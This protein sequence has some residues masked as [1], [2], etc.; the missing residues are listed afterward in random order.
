M[1]ET[2]A[3]AQHQ[4]QCATTDDDV[5]HMCLPCF[6]Q[7]LQLQHHKLQGLDDNASRDLFRACHNLTQQQLEALQLCSVEEQLRTACSGL[8]L[9]LSIIGGAL[10]PDQTVQQDTVKLWQVCCRTSWLA[11]K[12]VKFEATVDKPPALTPTEYRKPLTPCL[13]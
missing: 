5:L 3:V 11:C 7:A 10:R 8:P 4:H 12:M 9:A 13:Y 6:L 1:S 2:V